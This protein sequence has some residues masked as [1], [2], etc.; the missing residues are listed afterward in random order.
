MS[1]VIAFL[2]LNSCETDLQLYSGLMY[3]V[4]VVNQLASCVDY[5][6]MVRR[7]TSHWDPMYAC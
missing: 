3:G 6:I 7:Q 2:I 1:G 5:L 4:V